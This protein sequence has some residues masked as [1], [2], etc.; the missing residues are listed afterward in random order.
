MS[1]GK[2]HRQD[3]PNATVDQII[4]NRSS[5]DLSPFKSIGG[6]D[7]HLNQLRE[8][9]LNCFFRGVAE[10]QQIHI[11]GGPVLLCTPNPEQLGSFQNKAIPV[12]TFGEALEESSRRILFHETFQRFAT[13]T[14]KVQESGTDGGGG[15]FHIMAS[16]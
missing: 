4:S 9:R 3:G 8:D 16:R 11:A 10:S 1:S 2:V 12:V 13:F 14:R 5:F 7:W 6:L 15:I